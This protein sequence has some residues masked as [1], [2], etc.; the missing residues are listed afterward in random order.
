MLPY[1]SPAR[2]G[3]IKFRNAPGAQVKQIDIPFDL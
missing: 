2:I 3:S 1:T